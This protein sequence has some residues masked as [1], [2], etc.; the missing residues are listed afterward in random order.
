M[1][2]TSSL[3]ALYKNKRRKLAEACKCSSQCENWLYYGIYATITVR[4]GVSENMQVYFSFTVGWKLHVTTVFV[5]WGFLR[6][7]NTFLKKMTRCYCPSCLFDGTQWFPKHFRALRGCCWQWLEAVGGTGGQAYSPA[8]WP[9]QFFHVASGKSRV[10]LNSPLQEDE[11]AILR[12]RFAAWVPEEPMWET[13][14]TYSKCFLWAQRLR[15]LHKYYQSASAVIGTS[16][17]LKQCL[18]I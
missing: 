4:K 18:P 7:Q 15:S 16:S 9:C 3:H 13:V 10:L 2:W 8:L 12:L 14:E 5:N 1:M 6:L 17:G 11:D